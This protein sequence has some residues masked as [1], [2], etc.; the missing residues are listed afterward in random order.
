MII[1]SEMRL[2][3][4]LQGRYSVNVQLVTKLLG[5]PIWVSTIAI[6]RNYTQAQQYI[7]DNKGN[8]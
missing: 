1:K 7:E 3:E 6:F 2:V 4:I 8:L 5:I